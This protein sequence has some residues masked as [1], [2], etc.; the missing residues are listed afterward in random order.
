MASTH[1]EAVLAV[2]DAHGLKNS[3][4]V[5]ERLA[6]AHEHNARYARTKIVGNYTYLVNNLAHAKAARIAVL[7]GGAK[8]AAQGAAGLA[9]NADGEAVLAWNANGFNRGAVGKRN[10]VLAG[11]I[12]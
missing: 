12:A 4:I 5:K 7:A 8:I 2:N 10:E 11:T 1:F 3:V 9:G 6:L